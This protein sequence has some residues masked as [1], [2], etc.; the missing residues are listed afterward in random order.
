MCS[1]GYIFFFALFSD[2]VLL[3]EIIRASVMGFCFGVRRAVELAEKALAENP[4]K[5]VYWGPK[6]ILKYS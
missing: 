6:G 5:K 4:G 2:K 1:F 3:M